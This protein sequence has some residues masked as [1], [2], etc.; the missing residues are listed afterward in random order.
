[1][2]AEPA[3]FWAALG[4]EKPIAGAVSDTTAAARAAATPSSSR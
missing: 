2:G 1:M 3:A 4:G